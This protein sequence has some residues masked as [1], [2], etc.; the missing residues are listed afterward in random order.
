MGGAA[1]ICARKPLQHAL[2]AA[3]LGGHASQRRVKGSYAPAGLP[4]PDALAHSKH[5]YADVVSKN[6][7][8][9]RSSKGHRRNPRTGRASIASRRRKVASQTLQNREAGT[10]SNIRGT[11]HVQDIVTEE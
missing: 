6:D 1:E 10:C 5:R 7:R 8:P 11:E 3:V 4:L 2:H 9:R